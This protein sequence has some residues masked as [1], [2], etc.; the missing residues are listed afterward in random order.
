MLRAC[1]R[2]LLCVSVVAAFHPAAL[3][4]ENTGNVYG[5]AVDAQGGALPGATVSLTGPLAPRATISDAN[6]QFRFLKV[7]PGRYTLKLTLSGFASFER[8]NVIVTLGKSTDV[9]A[10]LQLANVT[11]SVTVTGT[12]PLIDTRKVETGVTFSRDELQEVPTARDVYALMQQ[13]PGVQLDTVNVGGN[14]SG[15]AGGPDFSS[16]GSGGVTYQVDGATIT[17]NSYGSFNG[18]QAR[19]SGGSNTFFDFDTFQEVQV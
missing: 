18:G 10:E 8:D 1:V 7:P 4:Q 11:E 15:T 14:A 19:Q 17:D 13:V 12:T 16:K 3:S 9:A 2:L 5:R 6:G